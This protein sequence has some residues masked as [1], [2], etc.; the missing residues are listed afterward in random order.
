MVWG[1]FWH[2]GGL[3]VS[4]NKLHLCIW[5]AWL[6]YTL[7]EVAATHVRLR[8]PTKSKGDAAEE[9]LIDL[10]TSQAYR[11]D[12]VS[13]RQKRWK[14]KVLWKS[15]MIPSKD[16]GWNIC[17][18]VA[19]KCISMSV[20]FAYCTW[21]WII[22]HCLLKVTGHSS[23]YQARRVSWSYHEA[24]SKM[25]KLVQLHVLLSRFCVLLD[26]FHLIV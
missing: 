26:A 18:E 23:W 22:K 14:I 13:R 20:F 6:W 21:S 19:D 3:Q 11:L 4:R 16:V 10:Q 2:T 1:Q 25:L 5:L 7:I 17:A 12:D 24:Y 15:G 8:L 9:L